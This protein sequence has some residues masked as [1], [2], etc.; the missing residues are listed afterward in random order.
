MDC[1]GKKEQGRTVAHTN[2]NNSSIIY[3]KGAPAARMVERR[4]PAT[5]KGSMGI[6]G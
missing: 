2:G 3:L 5:L 4:R 6:G 1:L